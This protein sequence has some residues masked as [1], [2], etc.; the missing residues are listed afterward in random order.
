M[1]DKGNDGQG[2]RNIL[3]RLTRVG[4]SRSLWVYHLNTGSCNA[5]DTELLATLGSRYD[6]ENLG[7]VLVPTPKQA[8]VVLVTGPVTRHSQEAFLNTLGM[9]PEPRVVVALGTCAVSGEPFVSSPTVV[10]PADK[11]VQIDLRVVGC[12]VEPAAIIAAILKAGEL[13]KRMD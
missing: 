6:V 1:I 3:S 4:R 12:P 5:C 9:V 11:F 2:S 8:D 13:L 7:I 10:G